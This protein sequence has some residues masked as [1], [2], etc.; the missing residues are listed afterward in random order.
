[1]PIQHVGPDSNG[2]YY[3]VVTTSE[4]Q[5]PYG[6]QLRASGYRYCGFGTYGIIIAGPGEDC[7]TKRGS[8]ITPPPPPTQP[9]IGPTVP[10]ET[11]GGTGSTPA[12]VHVGGCGC[13]PTQPVTVPAPG[14]APAPAPAPVT[15]APH[16][17][18]LDRLKGLPWWVFVLALLAASQFFNRG[19]SRG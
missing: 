6:A 7:Y 11:T 8:T 5:G 19:S 1:M 10:P 2:N 18:V 4:W 12:P 16:V 15:M 9:N 14:G 17:V 3:Q 13:K